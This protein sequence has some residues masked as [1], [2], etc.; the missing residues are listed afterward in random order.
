M[1]VNLLPAHVPIG[2]V[3]NDS[4]QPIYASREL[5]RALTTM[6]QQIGGQS[7]A[8]PGDVTNLAAVGISQGIRVTATLP[9][10]NTLAY[11]EAWVS[12]DA[13]LGNAVLQDQSQGLQAS[14]DWIPLSA[15]DGVKY[16]WIRCI[17][18]AGKPGNFVGPVS[19][20]AGLNAVPGTV[21][22]LSATPIIGGIRITGTL[23]TQLDLA[24]VEIWENTVNNVNT[25]TMRDHG[26]ASSYDRIGLLPTDGT[27]YYW[28]RCVNSSGGKGAFAGPVSAIAGQVQS[29]NIASGAVQ[30]AAFAS[31]IE[32][33]TIVSAVPGVLSTKTIFN[34]TDGKLYRWNGSA[35][36]ASVAAVD[37][38]GQ[39]TTTQITDNSIST[40]KLQANSVTASIIAAN[41][42]TASEIAA[43]AVTAG[44]IA[45]GA[46]SATEISVSQLSAIT[47]NLG[48]VT[49]GNIT[50]TANINIIGSATFDGYTTATINGSPYTAALTA[51]DTGHAGQ[52]GVYGYSPGG[53]GLS[54]G[55]Y[56]YSVGTANGTSDSGVF[57]IGA[58]CGV[59]G[60]VSTS[61]GSGVAVHGASGPF[62]GQIGVQGMAGINA[63]AIGVKATA[64]AGV[65]IALAVDGRMTMTNTTAVTNLNADL[66]DGNHAS[67][68]APVVHTHYITDIVSSGGNIVKAQYSPDNVT[69]TNIYLKV[70]NW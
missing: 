70:V 21:T 6:M 19:A 65:G 54:A 18:K 3:N 7:T 15:A 46:V 30:V 45:A 38:S 53:T 8:G 9:A 29:G 55:V 5:T 47:A 28:V 17:S 52:I 12:S 31:G 24:D 44:K 68:F 39:I 10:N 42:V 1:S 67:A 33:V 66:L 20:E 59:R 4:N 43:N 51:N 57:G 34:T 11:L 2:Y 49:A 13:I 32:P 62:S 61:S 36:V 41:A 69:W 37:I 16:I 40:A 58:I 25:A 48:S 64:L 22:G 56:G 50:G 35:Y 63:G 60:A 23:P 14:W 26:L 27:R